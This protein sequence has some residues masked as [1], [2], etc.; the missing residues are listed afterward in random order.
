MDISSLTKEQVENMDKEEIVMVFSKLK[1]QAEIAGMK[2]A[3]LNEIEVRDAKKV[4]E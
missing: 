1:E 4:I 2:K 3:I